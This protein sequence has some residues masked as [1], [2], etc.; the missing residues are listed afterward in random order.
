[1]RKEA[2]HGFPSIVPMKNIVLPHIYGY[3][4]HDS[5]ITKQAFNPSDRLPIKT[6]KPSGALRRPFNTFGFRCFLS[7]FLKFH[8]EFKA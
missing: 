7:L 6:V 3:E 1:M 8:P 4:K 2:P 5:F